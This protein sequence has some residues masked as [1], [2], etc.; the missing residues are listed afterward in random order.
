MLCSCQSTRPGGETWTIDGGQLSALGPPLAAAGVASVVAMQANVSQDTAATFASAFFAAFAEHGIVDEAMA[1]ARGA[2]RDEK[3]WWAP[4]LFS[5][6]RT[7]R[8]YY[9]PKFGEYAEEAWEGLEAAVTRGRLTPVLGPGLTDSIHGSLQD[10]ARGWVQRWQLPI[11]LR[12][13]S[14][15]AKVA[16]YLALSRWRTIGQDLLGQLAQEISDRRNQA[17]QDDPIWNLPSD[18]LEPGNLETAILQIGRRLRSIDEDDPHRVIAALPV[19]VYVTTGWTDLLQKALL[20]CGKEPTTLCFAWNDR[21]D[22]EDTT[23]DRISPTTEKPLVYHLFGRLNDP[24]SLVLTEDDHF[25]WLE[26]WIGR[27]RMIPPAVGKAF[28]SRSLLFLGFWPDD[29]HF[30]F[31][32]R[33]IKSLPGQLRGNTHVVVLPGPQNRAIE[34]DVTDQEFG[35]DKISI[36]WGETREFLHELR[37]RA[38]L[39]T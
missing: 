8:T 30:R 39:T 31:V 20:A 35:M 27:R 24:D 2:I 32:W 18:L 11:P 17:K 13:Q 36:Y 25:E 9:P 22:W 12:D 26:A 6:L 21:T 14:N 19:P 38:R 3:D 33:G 4:V 29:S 28:T 23:G 1:A 37:Q 10:I 15:L 16:Q 7:G 34:P 5:R